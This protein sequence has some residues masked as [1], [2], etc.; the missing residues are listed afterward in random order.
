MVQLAPK[1]LPR[2][3]PPII[4]ELESFLGRLELHTPRLYGKMVLLLPPNIQLQSPPPKILLQ[5][6]RPRLDPIALDG[7]GYGL[8]ADLGLVLTLK[9]LLL[10]GDSQVVLLPDPVLE[11]QHA[12]EFVAAFVLR[13]QASSL[14]C[15][16]LE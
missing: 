3:P 13:F 16:W 6:P 2:T 15:V 7:V 12:L 5:C 9:F 8:R 11:L 4:N 14:A 1:V 10:L